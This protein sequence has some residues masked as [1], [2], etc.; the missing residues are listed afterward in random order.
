MISFFGGMEKENHWQAEQTA[1][2]NWHVVLA[3]QEADW[4]GFVVMLNYR[5]PPGRKIW[6]RCAGRRFP[7]NDN[8]IKNFGRM[9]SH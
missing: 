4:N 7:M 6:Q 9:K 5:K 3:A 8:L 1:I 2:Y